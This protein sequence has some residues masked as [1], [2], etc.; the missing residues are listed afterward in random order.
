MNDTTRDA[1]RFWANS[2]LAIAVLAAVSGLSLAMESFRATEPPKKENPARITCVRVPGESFFIAATEVTVA[3]F[4]ACVQAGACDAA[5]V[6]PICNYGTTDREQ[7]PVNCVSYYGAEQFCTHAG[8]RLCT[9]VEWLGACRGP[10]GRNFPYGNEFDITACNVQS[11]TRPVEGRAR[12]TAPV[13]SHPR[14]EG[15]VEGVFDM[16]GNVTEWVNACKESYCRFRGAGFISNDPVDL[17]ASCQSACTGNDKSLKSKT[18]GF[19]CCK[20]ENPGP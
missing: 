13:A 16:N 18:V 5:Q 7:H 14:C 6:D 2:V 1:Q 3:Q 10:E 9:E 4:R 8:G 19:R 17:F 12:E 11:K 20:D 15:G